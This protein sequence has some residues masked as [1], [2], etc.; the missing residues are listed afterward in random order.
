MIYNLLVTKIY[1]GFLVLLLTPV[2]SSADGDFLSPVIP[3]HEIIK[4]LLKEPAPNKHSISI[5]YNYS[6]KTRRSIAIS[7]DN[8]QSIKVI[9]KHSNHSQFDERFA[10]SQAIALLEKVAASQSPVY[11][12][13]AKNYNDN[14]LPGRMDCIDATVNTTHYLEFLNNLG[15]LFQYELLLPIYRSPYFMGQHWAAQ[16]KNRSNGQ[17]YA[18]DSW[19]SDIGQAPVIQKVNLWKTRE[20]VE[21]L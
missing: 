9:F 11:N 10:I 7:Q 6:C 3:T 17:S 19:Q 4:K 16:I 5:C 20:A 12:D 8:I 13:K 2:F 21:S 18:V 15:L 1:M 14:G